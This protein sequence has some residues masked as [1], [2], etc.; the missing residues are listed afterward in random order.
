MESA[1]LKIICSGAGCECGV[2]SIPGIPCHVHVT[3]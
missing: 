1:F 3:E 2:A